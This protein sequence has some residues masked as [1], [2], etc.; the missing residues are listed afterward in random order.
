MLQ[1]Q[2]KAFIEQHDLITKREKVLV[3][4]S[5]GPDSTAL[6]VVLSGLYPDVAAIYVNHQLRGD[7]SKTEEQFVRDFCSARKIPLFVE[8]IRWARKP[9]DPEQSARKRRYRHFEKSARQ[10]GYQKVALAHQRDDVTET[11]LLNLIRGTGP[12]GLGGLQPQ[13]DMYVRPMLECTRKEVLEFLKRKNIPYFTDTSNQSFDFRR[14][15]VREELIPYIQ[16]HFNPEFSAGIYRTSKWIAE[17]NKILLTLL[18]PHKSAIRKDQRFFSLD[19]QELLKLDP[20]LQKAVLRLILAEAIP[21]L[22]LT[23]RNLQTV[24]RAISDAREIELP[25]FLKMIPHG[26]SIEFVHKGQN[27]GF[28][29]VDVPSP[30]KY[31]FPAGGATLRF[32]LAPKRDYSPMPDIAYLDADKASFPLYIRNWRKGDFIRPLGMKGR[33]KISDFLIDKKVPKN[34]RKQIPLVYKDDDL[35]W[36][37]GYQIHHDYRVTETTSRLLRIELGKDA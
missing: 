7:E 33:K 27:V 13:R 37:A 32:S 26:D 24:V 12:K 11:F 30:G 1:K 14:N 2:I 10:H 20:L 4:Y 18:Q 28:S 29:D 8:Q 21:H 16:K 15:R 35:I 6:L 25:G 36:V 22:K 34:L 19:R 31:R 17:Q 23:S 3:A 5:G 9:A